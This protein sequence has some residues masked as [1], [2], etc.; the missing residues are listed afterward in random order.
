MTDKKPMDVKPLSQSTNQSVSPKTK[1]VAAVGLELPQCF[2]GSDVTVT[3]DWTLKTHSHLNKC[4]V[5]EL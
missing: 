4:I 3:V 2:D 1:F 5:G